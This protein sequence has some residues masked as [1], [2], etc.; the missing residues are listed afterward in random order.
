MSPFWLS[1]GVAVIALIIVITIGLCVC[2]WMNRWR[3]N[4]IALLDA[5]ITLPLVLPPVVVGFA[6]LMVF[7]PGYAF[8]GWLEKHNLGVVFSSAGAVI[9]SAVISF[10]LFYQTVRS[11]LQSVDHNI[12][13]V[14]RTLGASELRIFF[15]ISIPLAWK[16]I[17]TGSI[18]AFCR[19]MGEFGATI[20]IAGNI[21]GLTRTMP[22]AIYSYVEAG[23]Y[24]DAFELVIY[25]C[26]L[27][28][29]LLSSIHL[30][31]KGSMFRNIERS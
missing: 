19:A 6:L 27:T 23:Q 30:L 1:I 28:L 31:T 26:V 12:E 24:M 8:G 5:I 20:L 16:G 15:T 3:G 13:D 14:A 25:I 29:A 17:L 22:L 9:A 2:F 7:S 4:V 18:L 11:A 10:P 21:P